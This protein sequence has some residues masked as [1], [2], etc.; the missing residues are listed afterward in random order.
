MI[1]LI[2][3]QRMLILLQGL[4]LIAQDVVNLCPFIE[5]LSVLRAEVCC[6][7][8][9]LQGLTQLLSPL[10]RIGSDLPPGAIEAGQVSAVVGVERVEPLR[11]DQHRLANDQQVFAAQTGNLLRGE[12]QRPGSADVFR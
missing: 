11:L 2:H 1:L 8:V 4:L 3:T 9:I 10:S 6:L 7:T 5:E 12:R